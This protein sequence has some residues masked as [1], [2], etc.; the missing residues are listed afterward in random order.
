[1]KSLVASLVV[2]AA[3]LAGA[4][5]APAVAQEAKKTELVND[6]G[7]SVDSL[8]LRYAFDATWVIDQ[9]RILIRDTY[10]DHYLISLK[11]DCA[12]LVEMQRGFT[13]VPPLSGRVR[14]GVVYE[15]R[16]K[17]SQPCDIA[18]LEQIS[19]E[20]AASLRAELLKG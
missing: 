19:D 16:D 7:E 6:K 13:F 18:K 10:R 9:K 12:K 1:M 14:A 11:D 8:L 5:V 20:Q 17:V 3:V 4:A 2:S 15:V